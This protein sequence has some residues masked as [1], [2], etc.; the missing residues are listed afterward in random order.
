[1]LSGVL[2]GLLDARLFLLLALD[3]L[4]LGHEIVSRGLIET[5]PTKQAEG[6]TEKN[7]ESL[8]PRAAHCQHTDEI[9]KLR[10]VH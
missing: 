8:A 10:P 4:A 2:L 7:V 9:I 3:L 1:M 6:A 5:E